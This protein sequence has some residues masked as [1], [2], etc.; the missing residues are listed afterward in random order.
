MMIKSFTKEPEGIKGLL[1][2][3]FDSRGYYFRE[4]GVDRA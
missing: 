2:S 3:Q 4:A 1:G